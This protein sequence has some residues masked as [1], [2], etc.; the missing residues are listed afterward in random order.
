MTDARKWWPSDA[1]SKDSPPVERTKTIWNGTAAESAAL[2]RAIERHCTC[3]VGITG[4]LLRACATH[5][6]LVNNQRFLDGVLFAR[7]LR[8]RLIAEEWQTRVR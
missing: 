2:L 7:R 5:A 8:Q 6:A 3:E 4:A 1:V